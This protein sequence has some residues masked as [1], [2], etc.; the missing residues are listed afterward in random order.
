MARHSNDTVVLHTTAEA[1]A[2]VIGEITAYDDNLGTEISTPDTA[3]PYDRFQSVMVQR[4]EMSFTTEA[5]KAVLANI[6]FTGKCILSDGSHPGL[7]SFQRQHDPC[8][9]QGRKAG[10][11]H[12]RVTFANGH[13]LIQS[14]QASAAGN[15]TISLRASG[16]SASA[17]Q[18]YGLAY[19]AA[20]PASP[21]NDQQYAPGDIYVANIQITQ[22]TNVAV[23]YNPTAEAVI[24]ANSLWPTLFDVQKVRALITITTEDL[25][26]LNDTGKIALLGEAATHA[27]SYLRFVRRKANE[28]FYAQGDAEHISG[29]FAG[30]AHVSRSSSA[31][32][33]GVGTAQIQIA[34]VDD[35]TNEP[36]VWDT[37]AA[38]D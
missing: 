27:N 16:T 1:A 10:S 36:I 30:F 17:A 25:S 28:G 37:A 22:V 2:V 14:I 23:A 21:V 38:I 35:G 26:V 9:A 34:T 20:L 13:I 11:N 5:L 19:N 15:A 31:S 32:G 29:T 33:G 6:G 4:P 24:Y 3:H 12:R 8:G 18:P 7:Q